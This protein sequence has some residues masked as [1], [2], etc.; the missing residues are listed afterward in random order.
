[1]CAEQEQMKEKC[2]HWLREKYYKQQHLLALS[3]SYFDP[4]GEV[5]REWRSIHI[6]VAEDKGWQIDTAEVSMSLQWTGQEMC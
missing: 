3:F 4:S 5:N 6:Y 1:M 2:F